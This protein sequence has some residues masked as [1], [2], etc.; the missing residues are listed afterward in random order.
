MLRCAAESVSASVLVF[1]VSE[2]KLLT[3]LFVWKP[4]FCAAFD[5]KTTYA[6]TS[7]GLERLEVVTSGQRVCFYFTNINIKYWFLCILLF[8]DASG[9]REETLPTRTI[10][11]SCE[12][13][14]SIT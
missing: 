12:L 11:E 7:T 6:Q 4:S 13:M 2:W 10:M 14:F 3:W 9:S 8:H 1:R 5:Q